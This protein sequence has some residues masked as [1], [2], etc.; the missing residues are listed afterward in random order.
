ML[1]KVQLCIDRLKANT[2]VFFQ[3]AY[4]YKFQKFHDCKS[5]VLAFTEHSVVPAYVMS[6]VEHLEGGVV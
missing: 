6:Y 5:D 1:L 2:L 4:M 3:T